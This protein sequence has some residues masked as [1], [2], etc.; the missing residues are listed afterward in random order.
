MDVFASHDGYLVIS[1]TRSVT[2][3]K[4]HGPNLELTLLK[5]S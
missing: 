2:F 3:D 5:D 1:N 4:P